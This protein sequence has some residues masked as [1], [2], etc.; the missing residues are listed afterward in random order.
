M[1]QQPGCYQSYKAVA[2]RA[3]KLNSDGTLNQ[4][5][6]AGT[7]YNMRPVSVQLSPQ[8]T[9]GDRIE[10]KAGD[11]SLCV[12]IEDPDTTTG[13]ELTVVLCQLDIELIE[14][15]TSSDIIT[16]PGD[17]D[18][19]IGFIAP[20]PDTEPDPVEFHVWSE[21]LDGSE[22]VAAPYSHWHW[23]FPFTQWNIGAQTLENGVLTVTL[24][25]KA[26]TNSSIGSGSFCDLPTPITGFFGVYLADDVP[27][28]DEDPYDGNSAS[29]GWIDTPDCGS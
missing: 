7:A 19:V 27:D 6:T 1:P 26:R 11:G 25:G 10:Q 13:Y 21:A 12:V 18:I 20:E 22:Q 8:V 16:D 24:T 23:V 5:L 17:S 9:T 3:S 2:I 29:C 28:P 4:P 14:V 15:M